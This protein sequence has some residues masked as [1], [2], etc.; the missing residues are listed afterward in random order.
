[1]KD[2]IQI[3]DTQPVY[4]ISTAAEL[5]G[6]S[7]HTLRMYEREG[8]FIPFKRESNQRQYSKAD[9]DRIQCLRNAINDEKISIE[10]IKRILSMIPCWKFVG[11]S[12]VDLASCEAYQ[13]HAKPCWAYAHRNN[14][15][16]GRNCRICTVYENYSD[17]NKIKTIIKEM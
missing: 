3:N 8:L 9:L 13:G 12:E 6:I 10:G 7:V 15:C 1:M 17:C 14:T 4:S 16:A 2:P 11:C 5:L